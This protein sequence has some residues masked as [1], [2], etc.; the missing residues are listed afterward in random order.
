M[1]LHNNEQISRHYEREAESTRRSLANSLNELQDRLTPGQVF[2]EAL[3]YAKSGSGSFARAFSNAMR[4]NPFPALLIGS[5]CMMFLSEKMGITKGLSPRRYTGT[6]AP[7]DQDPGMG[8]GAKEKVHSATASIKQGFAA[9]GDKLHNTS[10]RVKET[11]HDM[12]E[13]VSETV[14]EI[15]QGAQSVGERLTDTVGHTGEQARIAGRQVKNKA[16]TLLH[17]Q[18]LLMAG[19]GVALGAVLAA[20]LPTTRAENRLLG[21]TSDR[22]KK[23]IRDTAAQQYETVKD[24]AGELVEQAKAVAEREGVTTAGTAAEAVRRFT[25]NGGE[26]GLEARSGPDN[27]LENRS[28]PEDTQ[29]ADKPMRSG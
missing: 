10:E 20:L 7:V 23:R 25:S 18:P 24:T 6:F 11:V 8:E 2:D 29:R 1:S 15:K 28:W 9:V 26:E 12:G 5:G 22:L 3:S 19:V 21:E 13:S 16:T 17:E 27:D 14:D 4:D